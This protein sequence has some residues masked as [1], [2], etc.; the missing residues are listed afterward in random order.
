MLT[1]VVR[2]LRRTR[3]DTKVRY[4]TTVKQ[5]AREPHR[6]SDL[7]DPT[8]ARFTGV[9]RDVADL[10]PSTA[11]RSGGGLN[12]EIFDIKRVTLDKLTPRLDLI[13]HQGGKDLVRTHGILDG[14]PQKST[15]LGIHRRV[16]E[17]IRIH[18]A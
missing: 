3:F 14:H 8:E 16:P 9:V 13:A 7:I 1:P 6:K 5:I 11:C 2:I 17:L 15:G 18:L 10:G 12:V 4:G